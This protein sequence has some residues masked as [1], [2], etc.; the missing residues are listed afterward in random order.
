MSSTK[1]IIHTKANTDQNQYSNL[2]AKTP[3]ISICKS[4]KY[5][6][7]PKNQ[8]ESVKNVLTPRID[9]LDIFHQQADYKRTI[10]IDNEGNNN[11][12]MLPK[13]MFSDNNLFMKIVKSSI[14]KKLKYSEPTPKTTTDFFT[15][16]QREEID[17]I[18]PFDDIGDS[19]FI[20]NSDTVSMTSFLSGLNDLDKTII[21]EDYLLQPIFTPR[22]VFNMSNKKVSFAQFA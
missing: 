3:R 11:F 7:K 12:K 20:K 22:Q 5:K 15:P 19:N 4:S 10:I 8:P 18:K 9:L 13:K 1:E 16:K 17:N 2:K 14:I 21:Q 6:Y